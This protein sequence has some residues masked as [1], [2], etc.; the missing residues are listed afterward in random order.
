MKIYLYLITGLAI[1]IS[2]SLFY[3]YP[4]VATLALFNNL[5]TD[6]SSF[7]TQKHT[8]DTILELVFRYNAG[9]SALFTFVLHWFPFSK[10]INFYYQQ[11]SWII[12]KSLLLVS[13]FLTFISFIHFFKSVK[14]RRIKKISLATVYFLSFSLMLS[15]LALGF[16]D[17]FIAPVFILGLSFLFRKRYRLAIT[18][19]VISILFNWTLLILAPIFSIYIFSNKSSSK[20]NTVFNLSLITLFAAIAHVNGYVLAPTFFITKSSQ[21]LNIP[22]LLNHS[23][24]YLQ[25]YYLLTPSQLTLAILP[26]ILT[27]GVLF[28]SSF[29]FI[30]HIFCPYLGKKKLIT[31]TFIWLTI[32]F[33]LA[34]LASPFLSLTFTFLLLYLL[35]YKKFQNCKNVDSSTFFDF[36]SIIYMVFLVFFPL[37]SAGNL[38]WL[39]IFSIL[40]FMIS[41]NKENQVRLILVNVL[42]FSILFLTYGNNGVGPDTRSNYIEVF[43]LFFASIFLLLTVWQLPIVLNRTTIKKQLEASRYSKV[44]LIILILLLNFSLIPSQ[45]TA[46]MGVFEGFNRVAILHANPF[47]NHTLT[48]NQYPPLSTVIYTAFTHLYQN[49]IGFKDSHPEVVGQF[50]LATKISTSVFYMISMGLILLLGKIIKRKGGLNKT[51]I[52]LIF[53]T[54]FSLGLQSNSLTSTDILTA[55]TIILAIICLFKKKYFLAGLF[56]GTSASIKWQPVAL[57][58]LFG[59]TVFS[60]R[61]KLSQTLPSSIKLIIGLLFVPIITWLLILA[62]PNGRF[63]F[64]IGVIKFLIESPPLLSGLAMNLNWI[65]TYYLHVNQPQIFGSPELSNWMNWQIGTYQAPKIFQGYF[66]YLISGIILFRYWLFSKKDLPHFLSAAVLIYFSHYMFNKGVYQN[67]SFYF[68]FM[69]LMLYLI[70]PTSKNRL[71]LILFDI[72]N[73]MGQVFFYGITGT[74]SAFNRVFLR[75][76]LTVIFAF[77]YLVVYG[78]VIRDYLRFN[79]SFSYL[80]RASVKLPTINRN[81]I[82]F[83]LVVT[84]LLFVTLKLPIFKFDSS[85]FLVNPRT[86]SLTYTV[87]NLIAGIGLNNYEQTTHDFSPDLLKKVDRKEFEKIRDGNY[88]KVGPLVSLG[89]PIISV[90]RSET[91]FKYRAE[92]SLDQ[93][94]IEVSFKKNAEGQYKVTNLLIDS[95]KLH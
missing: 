45:G 75:V 80:P 17:L 41:P 79:S 34:I 28:F 32:T 33:A 7:Q 68:V 64:D 92:F 81:V 12:S 62:Q 40:T 89:K 38:I 73:F 26:S 10:D 88:A 19:Y 58:P 61:E 76:D 6:P 66:F 77:Y 91:T 46:D 47:Y 78:V 1:L 93:G 9:T 29:Y 27:G 55:P 24:G 48:D 71:I 65:V 23:L 86:Q 3:N 57:F 44:F 25:K 2:I 67:H 4:G 94:V 30:K 72:M 56:L 5:L 59:L 82:I 70:N 63:S 20:L 54:T 60:L 16:W 51:N 15:N 8:V 49:I 37:V 84:T 83:T 95:P 87:D 39:V 21:V 36:I 69:M 74:G 85:K 18:F 14:T 52:L 43:K 90:N 35:V 53:L 42:A 50:A 31:Y 22:W 13:Y 11:H